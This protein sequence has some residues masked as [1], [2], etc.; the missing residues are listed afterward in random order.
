MS[1]RQAEFDQRRVEREERIKQIIQSR[2]QDRDIKRKKIFYVR[3]KEET[4]RKQREEEEAR[5]R[6]GI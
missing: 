1:H 2:K 3:S 4:I 6:E 5:K